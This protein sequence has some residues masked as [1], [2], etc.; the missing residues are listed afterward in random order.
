VDS[1]VLLLKLISLL[2]QIQF[3][4][5][6]FNFSSASLIAEPVNLHL[7]QFQFSE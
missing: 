5:N 1:D 6:V 4:W 3:W 2:I 7:F